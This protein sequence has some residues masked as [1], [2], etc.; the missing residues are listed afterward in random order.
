MAGT[1]VLIAGGDTQ[2][3]ARGRGHALA[4]E[5]PRGISRGKQWCYHA[6]RRDAPVTLDKG[7]GKNNFQFDSN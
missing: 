7:T 3:G 5:V 4:P 2:G 1:Q 6:W